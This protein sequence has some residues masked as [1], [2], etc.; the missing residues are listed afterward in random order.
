MSG[1]S[2]KVKIEPDILKYARY[3]SGYSLQEVSKK[4]GIKKEIIDS[5]EKQVDEISI[6][7][8]KKLANIY[9]IPLAYFFL[10]KIPKDVVLPKD[11][12]IIYSSE[13]NELPPSVMLAIR[14]ARYVQS[15][16]QELSQEEIKYDFNKINENNNIE[17][18]ASE[19]RKLLNV[20]IEDQ[21]KWIVSS[22]AL[23]NWKEAIESL[24]IYILQQS[25]P[26]EVVSAF[27][28]VDQL[29]YTITL[30]SSDSENRRIFSLFHE[31]GHV[32]L[33]HS[34][35][36]TPDNLSRNSYQYIQIEKFCN[37]FAASLLV[38]KD[39]FL[40]DPDVLDII[41]LPFNQWKDNIIKDI[42]SKFGVSQEVI[43]RRFLTL[44]FLN[45][46]NYELKRNELRKNFEENKKK[47]KLKELHIPQYRKIISKNGYAYSSFVLEN[48]HS[49]RITMVEAADYLDTNSRHISAVEFHL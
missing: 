19:F 3:H 46:T 5:Y 6:A 42:S 47:K 7:K 24:H 17:K 26:E 44:G 21:H 20:S 38:P 12:R 29:P 10:K 49:N 8:L 27:C 23:K 15:I 34:G 13:E 48:L 4:S 25:L 45:E 40:E 37:Q 32:L 35:I 9:K 14:R 31:L 41:K 2:F 1:K 30:N 28:L 43:Y 36:C 11:F 22:T 18:S 39:E 16:I 33:H